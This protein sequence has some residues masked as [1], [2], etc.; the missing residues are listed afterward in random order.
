MARERLAVALRSAASQLVHGFVQLVYP[1][2]CFVCERA[3]PA[4]QT[5]FCTECRNALAMDPYPCCPRCART[6][7]PHVR[8]EGGCNTCR[9][10]SF[11][12]E[13]AVRLGPYDGKLRETILRLKRASG[14]G[15][16]EV[17][18]EL[19]ASHLETRLRE[20]KADAIIPVPLHWRRR[21]TRGY[22]QSEILAR[23]MA[24]HLRIPC[25]PRWL[26]RIRNTPRQIGQSATARRQNVH[27]A[28][29][30]PAR[31]ELRGTTILLV[32]DVLTTGHTASDAARA[33]R[34]A[35][36]ARAVVAALAGG[37]G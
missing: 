24:Q 10:E 22:N 33:L 2:S 12:F 35:G 31:T 29:F 3:L 36:A 15:L 30:S 25:H 26:R 21:L 7:G 8:L 20:L 32:D 11:H 28:F 27:K 37:H 1:A 19:W 23:S 14:E 17:L 34:A 5:H 6:V 18:G 13:R 16:A 9:D 4:E